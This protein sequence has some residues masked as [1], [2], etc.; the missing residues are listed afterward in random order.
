MFMKTKLSFTLVLLLLVLAV[1]FLFEKC[2]AKGGVAKTAV[3]IDN[4]YI[5]L[6]TLG[7]RLTWILIEL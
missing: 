3:S 4:N 6:S 7:P 2:C 1:S 5:I